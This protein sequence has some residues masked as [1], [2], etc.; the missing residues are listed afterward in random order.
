MTIHGRCFTNLDEYKMET[1]PIEFCA[2]PRVGEWV[3]S[4]SGVLLKVCGVIHQQTYKRENFYE[5]IDRPEIEVELTKI[6]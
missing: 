2:V 3:K 1:W 5:F 4:K 6:F